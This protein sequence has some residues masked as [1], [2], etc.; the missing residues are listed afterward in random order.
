MNKA[1]GVQ[2]TAHPETQRDQVSSSGKKPPK[3]WYNFD[4]NSGKKLNAIKQKRDPKNVFS[5]ASKVKWSQGTNFHKDAEAANKVSVAAINPSGMTQK[6]VRKLD[7]RQTT[8]ENLISDDSDHIPDS[9]DDHDV[10]EKY[11]VTNNDDG[12]DEKCM[13]EDIKRLFSITDENDP[14][15]W[16]FNESTLGRANFDAIENGKKDDS[17]YCF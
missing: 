5:L 1:E 15:D 9:F 10:N 4:E 8:I 6:N 12:D 16:S 13:Q 11:N 3:G 14:K 17:S 2:S 7:L